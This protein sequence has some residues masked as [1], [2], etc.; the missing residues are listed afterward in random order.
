[1]SR[2]YKCFF[3]LIGVMI[4]LSA[5]CSTM[6]RTEKQLAK[7]DSF[8]YPDI[9]S[10]G[11]IPPERPRNTGLVYSNDVLIVS[12]DIEVGKDPL[13]KAIRKYGAELIY[14]YK[15]IN[16]MAIRVA[17]PSRL[18][19]QI[20]RFEKVRGVLQVSRD[21]VHYLDPVRPAMEFK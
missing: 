4:L 19:E 8:D 15:I 17:D 10:P 6:S 21:Q 20:A 5:G 3:A 11:M 13:R 2:S 18:D 7:V 12:Y 16:A 9:P 1:M 14:D